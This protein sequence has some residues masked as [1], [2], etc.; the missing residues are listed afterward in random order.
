MILISRRL[1]PFVFVQVRIRLSTKILNNS[2]DSTLQH[3]AKNIEVRLDGAGRMM[4]LA[5]RYC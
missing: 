2:R 5:A 1:R 3:N 4:V